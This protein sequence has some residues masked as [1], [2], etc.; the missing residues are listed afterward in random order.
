MSENAQSSDQRPDHFYEDLSRLNN[1]LANLQRELA[2]K[3]AGL[4]RELAGRKQAEDALRQSREEISH[5]AEKLETQVRERT[6][7]LTATNEQLQA[8]VYSIAHDLRAPL[9]SMQGFSAM[10]VE[11]EGATLSQRG[12]EFAGRI[13]K[14]AQFMDH[15]LIDLL[16]FSRIAQQQ[17][18]LTPV[19]LEPIVQSVHSRLAKEL[20]E[21]KG[22][23]EWAG[24]WP[25][26]LAHEP[27]LGQVIFNLVSN[28]LKFTTPGRPPQVHLRAEEMGPVV[29]VWVE[30]NGIGIASEHQSQIFG[31]FTRLQGSKFPG[32]GIG[33]AIVQKSVERLGGKVG[34]ESTPGEGSRFWFEVPK[35]GQF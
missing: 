9:R 35:A 6:A 10:L 4:S 22:S 30:D 1:E 23:V 13:N 19:N 5:H 16:A 12:G 26:V 27:T 7:E 2:R 17:I 32:T 18:K 29:R 20:Q 14:S 21:K 33:L 25:T 15:L 3:N 11:E 34:L 28:A 31:L 24:P 8:F